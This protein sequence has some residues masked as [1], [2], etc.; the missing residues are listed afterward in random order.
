MEKRVPKIAVLTF[1]FLFL[2]FPAKLWGAGDA[3]APGSF[4]NFGTGARSQAM[5][6]AFTGLCDDASAIYWNPAGLSQLARNQLTFFNALLWEDTNY[7]FAG[8][9]H[10]TEKLGT[11]GFG[12]INLRSSDFEYRR[13]FSAGPENIFYILEMIDVIPGQEKWTHFV[14]SDACIDEN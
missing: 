6:S 14:L 5:G 2:I 12:L 13:T 8:Y 10:P 7:L 3:G 9:A 11:F 1:L 4:L